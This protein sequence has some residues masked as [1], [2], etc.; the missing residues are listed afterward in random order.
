L[1][2][3]YFRCHASD[4]WDMCVCVCVCV[5]VYMLLV[6]CSCVCVV[7]VVGGPTGEE[8]W[9]WRVA[10]GGGG[11]GGRAG[12]GG[13]GGA[14][15]GVGSL[16]AAGE[17]GLSA[18]ARRDVAQGAAAAGK[19]LGSSVSDG[20]SEAQTRL[21][22]RL[23]QDKKMHIKPADD[24]LT[25]LLRRKARLEANAAKQRALMA[26]L[27]KAYARVDKAKMAEVCARPAAVPRRAACSCHTSQMNRP[28]RAAIP[29]RAA[30]PPRR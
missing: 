8:I 7:L 2:V 11:G 15:A 13:G 3:F 30:P 24:A 23:A 25:R 9:W 14:G 5:C 21:H 27:S 17:D 19:S 16:G 18:E 28:A 22:E 4:T 20:E 12:P 26:A 10:C 1:G 6:T 29:R